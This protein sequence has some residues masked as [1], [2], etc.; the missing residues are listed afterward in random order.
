MH[1][2]FQNLVHFLC[3]S[4]DPIYLYFMHMFP[5]SRNEL[6]EYLLPAKASIFPRKLCTI[7]FEQDKWNRENSC[8]L[9]QCQIFFQVFQLKIFVLNIKNYHECS[10]NVLRMHFTLQQVRI[11]FICLQGFHQC[12]NQNISQIVH[13]PFPFDV[14]DSTMSYRKL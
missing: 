2:I 14:R 8:S 3:Q 6:Y 13:A 7:T 9:F 10:K 11:F 1:K 4:F 12:F 5:Y